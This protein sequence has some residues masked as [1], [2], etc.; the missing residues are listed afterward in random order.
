MNDHQ[1][2]YLVVSFRRIDQLLDE[3]GHILA[4]ADSTSPFAQYTQDSSPVQRKVVDDYIQD[5]GRVM[6]RSL[7]L[8]SLVGRHEV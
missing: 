2:R 4:T 3:A 5:V 6:A 1:Q 8:R 7:S